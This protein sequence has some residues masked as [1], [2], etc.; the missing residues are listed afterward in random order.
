M[1]DINT[2]SMDTK[3]KLPLM[4]QAVPKVLQVLHTLALLVTTPE[5]KLSVVVL[6]GGGDT[7]QG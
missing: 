1:A 6:L 3:H 5:G 2:L 7:Q 4:Y